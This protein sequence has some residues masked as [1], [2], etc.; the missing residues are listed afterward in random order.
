MKKLKKLAV[1]L[2]VA[3][4]LSCMVFSITASACSPNADAAAPTAEEMKTLLT[5]VDAANSAIELAVRVAQRTPFNDVK[6]LLKTVDIIAGGVF[7]YAEYIGADVVCEYTEY[8]VDGE[9]VLIDPIR[10]INIPVEKVR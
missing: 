10:V 8:V 2:V 1:V 3:T 7:C 9:T 4:I 5:M 6:M